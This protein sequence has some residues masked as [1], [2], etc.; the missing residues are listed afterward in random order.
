MMQSLLYCGIDLIVIA[1]TQVF[2]PLGCVAA[3]HGEVRL[4]IGR[5][6]RTGSRGLKRWKVGRVAAMLSDSISVGFSALQIFL[7]SRN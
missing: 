4:M 6:E 1:A 7:Y 2:D 3:T 5:P